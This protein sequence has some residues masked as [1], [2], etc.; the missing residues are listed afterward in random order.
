MTTQHRRHRGMRTQKVVAEWFAVHG[1]PYAEST[2]SA[3]SGADI[4]GAPDIAVE[5]KARADFS[6]LSW[7]RQAHSNADGRLPF[8]VLRC[9]GQGEVDPGQWGALLTLADLTNL[10][11]AAGYGDSDMAARP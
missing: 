10:L 9:N 3:R 6:P 2:G 8:V 11:I 7:L 1:W 4:T 5:V